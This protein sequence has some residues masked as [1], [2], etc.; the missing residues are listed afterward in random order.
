MNMPDGYAA[1]NCEFRCNST[2]RCDILAAHSRK[3]S[4]FAA[5][6]EYLVVFS[7]AAPLV[8]MR[9]DVEASVEVVNCTVASTSTT[10]IRSTSTCLLVLSFAASD[11]LAPA[12]ARGAL[13]LWRFTCAARVSPLIRFWRQLMS[14]D[15][16]Q[17]Y[18]QIGLPVVL[19]TTAICQRT[20]LRPSL[21]MIDTLS[22]RVVIS[23]LSHLTLGILSFRLST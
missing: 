5:G 2:A 3:F 18:A 21:V 6:V 1:V 19:H 12:E 16:R 4:F 17:R 7:G 8:S 10:Q 13:V 23:A 15:G 22:C 11:V 9:A 20:G 14:A